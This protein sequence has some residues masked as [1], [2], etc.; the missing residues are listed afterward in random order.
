[1]VNWD[2]KRKSAMDITC[3]NLYPIVLKPLLSSTAVVH[4]AMALLDLKLLPRLKR[5]ERS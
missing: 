3:A 1:M 5:Q 2:D 4:L